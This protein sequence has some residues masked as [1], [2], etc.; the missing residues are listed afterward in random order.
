MTRHEITTAIK[1]TATAVL[2]LGLFWLILA[3]A[4]AGEL[5]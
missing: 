4:H 2:T 3:I 1:G 5:F